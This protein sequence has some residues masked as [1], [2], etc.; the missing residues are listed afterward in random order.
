MV[1][2]RWRDER[3]FRGAAVWVAAA[4]GAGVS[5]G[6][7]DGAAGECVCGA[8]DG[9]DCAAGIFYVGKRGDCAADCASAGVAAGVAGCIAG[10]CCCV[11]RG[12]RA[13]ELP[14]SGTAGLGYG[15]LFCMWNRAG[16][17]LADG[18]ALWTADKVARVGGIAACVVGD[19]DLS[20]P[21]RGGTWRWRWMYWTWRRGIRFW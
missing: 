14:D 17:E 20:L 1:A 12:I 21:C 10:V 2:A 9:R 6:E 8:V 19:C 18:V 7:V 4:D 5:P 13:W 15:F 3:A 16:G 11:V